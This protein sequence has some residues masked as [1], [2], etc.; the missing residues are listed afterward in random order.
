[1]SAYHQL[2][3]RFA[4]LSALQGASA[5]LHWDSEVMLPSGSVEA[6]SEQLAALAAIEHEK[7]NDPQL[8]DWLAEAEQQPDSLND[9]QAA[10]LR[11]MRHRHT[12]ATALPDTLVQAL[13]RAST[14][15]EHRWRQARA[16]NDYAGFLPAFQ[17]ILTLTQEAAAC[18]AEALGLSAYDALLDQY[19]PGIRTHHIDG[20]FEPLRAF[21]PDFVARVQAHQQSRREAAIAAT[22]PIEAQQTLSRVL[23]TQLGFDFTRGRAD[24]STHP[25]CG[26]VPGDIRLTSRYDEANLIEGL[27]ATLHETGH[28]LYEMGLPQEWLLQP[29]GHAR[30]MSLHESQS[31]LVEMQ[32]GLRQSFLRW[33]LPHLQQHLGDVASDWRPEQLHAHLTRVQPSFIRVTADEVTYPLHILLRYDL[34][35]ALLSGDLPLADL[36]GAWDD[37]MQRLLGIRPAT[38]AEGCLQDTHWPGGAIGYFPTYTLGAMIAAQLVDTMQSELGDLDALLERGAFEP[39]QHWLNTHIHAQA[40]RLSTSDLIAQAT[41]QPLNGAIYTQHLQRRY[42]EELA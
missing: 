16:E 18:K 26:G 8:A 1:M 25:F 33:L 28:A 3:A 22:V 6:R 27:Y 14:K 9:W 37:A 38:V 39:V 2:E 30:G 23:M 12:H 11:E 15:A 17:E 20:Y 10:N 36:P 7:I 32:L 42:L 13:T 5:I 4:S 21:L 31:L 40:S 19:D 24:I 35:R 29:V 34:E 41:G